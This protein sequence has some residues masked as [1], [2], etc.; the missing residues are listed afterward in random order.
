ME[1]KAGWHRYESGASQALVRLRT[2]TEAVKHLRGGGVS[3]NTVTRAHF[4]NDDGDEVAPPTAAKAP[5]CA[6]GRLRDNDPMIE[7]MEDAATAHADR[8]LKKEKKSGVRPNQKEHWTGT[9]GE[10]MD[11][12]ME[13]LRAED[14]I[15]KVEYN[16]EFLSYLNN[17]SASKGSEEDSKD[18]GDDDGDDF[19]EKDDDEEEDDE[20]YRYEGNS[21]GEE[22]EEEGDQDDDKN[23]SDDERREDSSAEEHR[24]GGPYKSEVDS[25]SGDE[26]YQRAKSIKEPQDFDSD[27]EGYN[28]NPFIGVKV[29]G[30]FL[31][32]NV[33]PPSQDPKIHQLNLRM[34]SACDKGDA[35]EVLRMIEAGAEVNAADPRDFDWSALMHA[36]SP[37]PAAGLPNVWYNWT[38]A[39][40]ERRHMRVVDC[41]MEHGAR[42]DVTDMYGETP[43]HYAAVRGYPKLTQKLIELGVDIHRENMYGNSAQRNAEMNQKGNPRCMLAA[44]VI[45][46]AGGYDAGWPGEK[47]TYTCINTHIHTRRVHTY[48]LVHISVVTLKDAHAYI[49]TRCAHLCRRIPSAQ[50]HTKQTHVHTHTH[51]HTHFM[52][53]YN[54]QFMH[55]RIDRHNTHKKHTDRGP[56]IKKQTKLTKDERE[57]YENLP[58]YE[59][60]HAKEQEM[61]QKALRRIEM[62]TL[63]AEERKLEQND[64]DED[65]RTM[66]MGGE[67]FQDQDED[68]EMPKAHLRPD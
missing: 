18:D 14:I 36:C 38:A 40:V 58:D 4:F 56:E 21:N 44:D 51:T 5:R 10:T 16:D 9:P 30:W 23:N 26:N 50:K 15:D 55:T 11:E 28:L 27:D 68:F 66:D 34:W 35:N 29:R 32:E 39:Q 1:S 22:E 54:A 49:L 42:I 13:G 7:H 47:H 45:A 57:Y 12:D 61:K 59:K 2:C 19:H 3:F 17:E 33:D 24:M 46:K 63:Q 20:D 67:D 60:E 64:G 53:F 62:Q 43:L 8:F 65:A 37:P 31:A 48:I 25:L 52:F 6:N 41:L